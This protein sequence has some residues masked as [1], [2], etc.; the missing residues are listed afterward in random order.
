MSE[1]PPN[2]GQVAARFPPW[3]AISALAIVS[4][5]RRPVGCDRK[6]APV[7]FYR[8]SSSSFRLAA[9]PGPARG[10][11]NA[12]SDFEPNFRPIFREINQVMGPI[13]AIEPSACPQRYERSM[14]IQGDTNAQDA[15]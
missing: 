3:S 5:H 7:G 6:G 15:R 12:V 2:T 1:V 4:V 9:F 13:K 11:R 8:T 14:L 10:T